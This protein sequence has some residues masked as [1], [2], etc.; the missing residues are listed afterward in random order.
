MTV[1]VYVRLRGEGR[2]K[3]GYPSVERETEKTDPQKDRQKNALG[4]YI[5]CGQIY[6]QFRVTSCTVM[7]ASQSDKIGKR[8]HQH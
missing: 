7:F 6:P 2:G 5:R 8:E 3:G 4:S 1:C